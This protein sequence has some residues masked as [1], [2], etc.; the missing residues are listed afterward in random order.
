M[1]TK[2]DE[3]RSNLQSW[4]DIQKERKGSHLGGINEW[5]LLNQYVEDVSHL[6]VQL[7]SAEKRLKE[8]FDEEDEEYVARTY[9]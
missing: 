5:A 7:D 9:R 3:I 4:T 8:I 2:I 6:L 1:A